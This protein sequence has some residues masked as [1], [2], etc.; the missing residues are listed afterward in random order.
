MIVIFDLYFGII[1][2]SIEIILRYH[3][4][5]IILYE[6]IDAGRYDMS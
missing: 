2:L 3:H 4:I 1:S 6:A 5:F